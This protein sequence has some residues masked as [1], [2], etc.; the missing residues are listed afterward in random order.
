M[1]ENN[2]AV[3]APRRSRRGTYLAGGLGALLL[4]VC[5]CLTLVGG[6]LV[7]DPFDLY[8]LERL[9]GRYDAALVAVPATSTAY[10]SLNLVNAQG[11]DLNRVIAAFAQTVEEGE[12]Q[13]AG[14][15]L[16]RLDEMLEEEFGLTL[17]EDV[18]PWIGQ[19]VGFSLGQITLDEFGQPQEIEWLSK[20]Y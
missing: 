3:P 13:T 4:L 8:V 7:I 14:D 12:L 2:V 1:I 10:A 19:Y 16:D 18:Q 17:R 5:G 11:E 15:A 9:T 20:P 6:V